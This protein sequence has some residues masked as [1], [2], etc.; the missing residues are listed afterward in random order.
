M[1]YFAAVFARVPGGW[2][3]DEVDLDD[4]EIL[5]EVTDVIRDA[6]E[7]GEPALLFV[8]E[9]DE[10]FAILRVDGIGEP[11]VFISDVRAPT[12]SE[13]A[14]L[15]YEGA[16]ETAQAGEDDEEEEQ[17]RALA[18]EPGGDV[19]LLEDLGIPADELLALTTREGVLPGDVISAVADRVSFAGELDKLR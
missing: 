6:A 13:L 3:G 14:A 16:E 7:E 9:D 10:W 15:L 1:P 2:T 11:R 17:A 5:D 4:L 8:E 18:D 12:T 19:D